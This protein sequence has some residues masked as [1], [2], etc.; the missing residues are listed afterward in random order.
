MESECIPRSSAGRSLYEIDGARRE[1]IRRKQE[2][3]VLSG[4][5]YD[6]NGRGID[7]I[8]QLM[9][10]VPCKALTFRF[11]GTRYGFTR[12]VDYFRQVSHPPLKTVRFFGGP[13]TALPALR[14]SG[15]N[16]QL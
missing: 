4:S 15:S 2:A 6:W 13:G 14:C 5:S 9:C 16:G 11:Y 8:E 10:G 1:T 3:R 7:D 12:N